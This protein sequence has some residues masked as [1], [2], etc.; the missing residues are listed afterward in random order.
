MELYILRHGEAGKR[1]A[2]GGKDSERALTVTGEQE[3]REVA[4]GLA[5]LEI[6]PDFVASSPLARARQSSASRTARFAGES[7]SP[8]GAARTGACA[9]SIRMVAASSVVSVDI[10]ADGAAEDAVETEGPGRGEA[11]DDANWTRERT[12]RSRT[13]KLG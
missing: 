9:A 5:E 7:G 10:P 13:K 11:L 4:A 12:T 8:T 6:K 3:V 2:A 1:L